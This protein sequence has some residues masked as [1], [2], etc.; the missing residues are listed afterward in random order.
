MAYNNLTG[1]V[2][3][4]EELLKIEGI[5]AGVVSGNLSTSDGANIINVPRLD[6]AVE[7]GIVTNV[8]GDFNTLTS[9]ANLRFDGSTLTLTGDLTASIGV[10]ASYFRGDGRYLTNLP[11]GGGSGG[12]IFTEINGTQANTTSSILVGS[13]AT[14]AAVIHIV[15]SSFFSGAVAHKRSFVNS[16]YSVSTTDY[17]IGVSS[18]GATVT[19]TLPAATSML[20]GQTLIVKDEGG[21][22]H[23]NNITITGSA[24]S[25]T[26]DGE[27]EAVLESPYASF[28]LYCDGESKF[29]IT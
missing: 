29:F 22:A 6:N 2:L 26:I 13:N 21:N 23:N 10:S 24:D 14:P 20:D 16:N 12:G 1:T 8:G 17:Y 25:N 28:Q 11:G 19:L 3:L 4:P 9:E 27:K 5:N 18:L 7:N 15:G